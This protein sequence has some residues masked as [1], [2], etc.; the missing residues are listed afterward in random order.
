MCDR[1][2]KNVLGLGLFAAFVSAFVV[3]IVLVGCPRTDI[4]EK[5]QAYRD[6]KYQG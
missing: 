3:G 6:G 5:H 2:P 1:L 4:G